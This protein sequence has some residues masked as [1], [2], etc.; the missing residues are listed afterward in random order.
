MSAAPR[1]ADWGNESSFWIVV[2]PGGADSLT[3]LEDIALRVAEVA[4]VPLR[5][6][7]SVDLSDRLDARPNQTLAGFMNVIDREARLVA[8]AIVLGV[9]AALKELKHVWEPHVE[10]HPAFA[11]TELSEAEAITVK[12]PLCLQILDD[13]ANPVWPLQVGRYSSSSIP[14]PALS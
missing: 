14:A 1:L 2:L 9:V 4:P 12:P 8:R 7:S 6:R 3:E 5:L 11:R 10:V 13:Y